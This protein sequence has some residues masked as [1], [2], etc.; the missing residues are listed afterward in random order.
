MKGSV[1]L[2][3]H[4]YTEK[5][6]N[7]RACDYPSTLKKTL[8]KLPTLPKGWNYTVNESLGCEAAELGIYA[9]RKTA[10]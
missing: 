5:S 9:E 2:E 7:G 3:N 4:T 10:L 8:L 1:K 6:G